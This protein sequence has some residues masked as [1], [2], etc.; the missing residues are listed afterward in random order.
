MSARFSRSV[1]PCIV[2]WPLSRGSELHIDML[3]SGWNYEKY[4]DGN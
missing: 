2:S 4:A 3:G 1:V